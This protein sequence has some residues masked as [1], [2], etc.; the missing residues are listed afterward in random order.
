MKL[1]K[2]A[3]IRGGGQFIEDGWCKADNGLGHFCSALFAFGILPLAVSAATVYVDAAWQG[4]GG[5]GSSE[6]PFGTLQ[7]AASAVSS[8]DKISVADGSYAGDVDFGSKIITNEVLAGTATYVG[9]VATSGT[10]NRTGAGT[11]VLNG[12]NTFGSLQVREGKTIVAPPNAGVTNKLTTT[13]LSLTSSSSSLIVSNAETSINL[14]STSGVGTRSGSNLAFVGGKLTVSV[15]SGRY[16][17]PGGSD[18][19]ATASYGTFLLD[20]VDAT[21][22]GGGSLAPGYLAAGRVIITNETSLKVENLLGRR[23]DIYQYSGKVDVYGGG[24]D[25]LTI[26]Y[27]VGLTMNYYIYGGILDKSP[28]SNSYRANIGGCWGQGADPKGY[29]YVYGGDV[30]IRC[31]NC[32]IGVGHNNVKQTGGLYVRGGNF[33]MPRDSSVLSVGYE[34]NGT[35]EVSN[36]GVA[37]INGSVIVLQESAGGRTSSVSLLSNGTLKARRLVSNAN[38]KGTGDKATLVLDG[39]KMIA[40]TS[41]TAE[42]MHG[43]TAA[44]VGVSGVVIDT[45]GQSLTIAQSFAARTGTGQSAPTAATAAELAALPAFTKAGAGRLELTGANEWLCATCVSNGTLAVGDAAMPAT[46]TLQLCGGVIDLGGNSFTVANL[47]GYGIVSNGT[48]TVTGAVW[49]GVYEP[50]TLKIDSTATLNFTKL[51]CYV[52]SV[53]TC[54]VLAAD[55]ALDL[56]GVTV[57]GENMGSKPSTRGLTLATAATLTGAPGVD[58]SLGDNRVSVGGGKLRV[59]A[60]G[61]V[62][63]F[64]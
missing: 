9:D 15:K 47:V 41:A 56:S 11:L 64:W 16:F 5:D 52:S 62:L 7:E 35:L 1:A 20:G 17:S 50:G 10:F 14:P 53:G 58:A 42:F 36:G 39:G 6:R 29:L 61:V 31:P 24:T 26:G 43:F 55:G 40:N 38:V 54:G 57:V 2:N 3:V 30:F 63:M 32:W 60:P 46:T 23:G 59:G 8:L 12:T 19:S 48:L 37:T 21:I 4:Q 45:A 18:G 44:S 51:G 34:G 13:G 22:S 33:T 28:S 49:P 27:N 25:A